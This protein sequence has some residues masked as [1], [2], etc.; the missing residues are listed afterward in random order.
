MTRMRSLPV[1][2]RLYP[3]E[4]VESFWR[5]L[6]RANAISSEDLWL[7]LRHVDRGLPLAVMPRHAEAYVEALGGLSAGHFADSRR[8]M[9]GHKHT[10]AAFAATRLPPRRTSSSVTLCRRCTR[11][12]TV[13]VGRLAGPICVRH[14]RW[15]DSGLD[16]DVRGSSSHL[17][18]QRILNGPLRLRGL[19][20]RT[21]EAEV[22]RNLIQLWRQTSGQ[23]HL[24]TN[25][26]EI[27]DFPLIVTLVFHLTEP[28]LARALAQRAAGQRAHAVLID[29]VVQTAL[30][31]GDASEAVARIVV[32]GREALVE[33]VVVWSFAERG[34]LTPLAQELVSRVPTLRSRLLR[35]RDV[36][37]AA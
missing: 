6:C 35:H 8:S 26:A 5:R 32:Q 13:V 19:A 17:V 20:Y 33:D 2:V 3:A 1:G 30:G 22:A 7:M 37:V 12:E 36:R 34:T 21:G 25:D 14:R 11:G 29:R 10:A 28:A 23:T 9:P 18:A 15:H 27:I 4:T 24:H 16:L 31:D